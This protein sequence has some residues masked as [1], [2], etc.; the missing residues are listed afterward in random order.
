MFYSVD[1]EFSIDSAKLDGRQLD[2]LLEGLAAWHPAVGTS[3]YGKAEVTLSVLAEDVPQALATLRAVL[4]TLDVEAVRVE[5]VEERLA[6]SR[7]G[8][9]HVPDL[10]TPK[11]AGDVLGVTRPAVLG[12]IERGELPRI[13]I[14]ERGTAIPLTAVKRLKD[15]RSSR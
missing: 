10:V 14:G 5:V 11:E 15:R 9:E 6:D 3:P 12:M 1:I 8:S 13:K 7:K 2:N 4:F